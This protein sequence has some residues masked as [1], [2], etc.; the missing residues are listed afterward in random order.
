[1]AVIKICDSS[2]VDGDDGASLFDDDD[3]DDDDNQ[4][5]VNQNSSGNDLTVIMI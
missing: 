2:L 5:L 4:F 3:D 1:M